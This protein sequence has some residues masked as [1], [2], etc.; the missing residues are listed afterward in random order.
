MK[1][2]T[3]KYFYISSEQ[4]RKE[5]RK[6]MKRPSIEKLKKNTK[7][8]KEN[9]EELNNKMTILDQRNL[10]DHSKLNMKIDHSELNMKLTKDYKDLKDSI[11]KDLLWGIREIR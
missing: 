8:L 10:L 6:I 1:K 7:E 4:L 11:L 2:K 9:M 3:I 5:L